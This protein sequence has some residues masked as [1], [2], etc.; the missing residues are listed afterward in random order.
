ML[1]KRQFVQMH[2]KTA[3]SSKCNLTVTNIDVP[4]ESDI[5]LTLEENKVLICTKYKKCL[6]AK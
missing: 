6:S 3:L 2:L 4:T 1:D 5:L